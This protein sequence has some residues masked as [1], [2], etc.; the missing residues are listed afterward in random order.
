MECAEDLKI[1]LKTV[2]AEFRKNNL[3]FCLAGGWA[4]SMIGVPR[5]T[6]DIDI[7]IVLDGDVKNKITTILANS[8][9]LLQSHEN[10]ME[11]KNAVIWRQLVSLK[12]KETHLIL[13]LLKA[14]NNFLKNAIKRSIEIDYEGV[15][16][17]IISIEDLI[18]I[19]LAAFRKQDQMDIENLIRAG[20]AIDWAYLEEAINE[21]SLDWNYILKLKSSN[22]I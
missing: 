9:N 7:L 21:S 12:N 6:L 4:V 10:E 16:I 18:I 22:G 8:F 5:T 11:L 2:C 1:L 19:K 15:A 3:Q 14:D 20:A 13:D 17:P